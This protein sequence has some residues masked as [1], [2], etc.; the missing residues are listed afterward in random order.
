[1]FGATPAVEDGFIHFAASQPVFTFASVVDDGTG[2]QFFVIAEDET[3]EVK[4]L[5]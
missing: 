1:M 3:G 5:P 4:P 2:D